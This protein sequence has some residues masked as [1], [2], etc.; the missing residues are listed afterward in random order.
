MSGKYRFLDLT[1]N[2]WAQQLNYKDYKD[3]RIIIITLFLM[4]VFQLLN[5]C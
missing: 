5:L 2:C 1:E 3:D 4:V